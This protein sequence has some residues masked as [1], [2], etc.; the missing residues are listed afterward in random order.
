MVKAKVAAVMFHND[1]GMHGHE[2]IEPAEV[3]GL[4]CKALD[5]GNKEQVDREVF[6]TA[7][8]DVLSDI[9]FGFVECFD[10]EFGKAIVSVLTHGS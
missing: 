5:I 4:P 6:V 9:A 10:I 2:F 3:F 7:D 1:C 8:G